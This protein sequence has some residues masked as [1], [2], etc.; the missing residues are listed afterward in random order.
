MR[1][2]VTAGQPLDLEAGL[3]KPRFREVDLPV[4][5]G[6]LVAAAHQERELIAISLVERTEV[7]PITLPSVI[8]HEGG[9][10]GEVEQA[11]VA[12]HGALKP[13]PQVL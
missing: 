7:E 5:K 11:I 4:L 6:I 10:G 1:R 3:T 2:E 8:G 9:S 13:A 12:V